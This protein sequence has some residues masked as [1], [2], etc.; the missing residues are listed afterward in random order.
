MSKEQLIDACNN[1]AGHI[2]QLET[3]CDWIEK[4]LI[5]MKAK[6]NKLER[7]IRNRL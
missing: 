1:I 4:Q 3:E 7:V 2:K 6:L 5:Y